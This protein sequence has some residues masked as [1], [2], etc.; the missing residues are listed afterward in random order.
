M[1]KSIRK[2]SIVLL[3]SLATLTPA[4]ATTKG[5]MLTVEIRSIAEKTKAAVADAE[6]SPTAENTNS[7][8]QQIYIWL[9]AYQ[10]SRA[11]EIQEIVPPPSYSVREMIDF[12]AHSV[13]MGNVEAASFLASYF[14]EQ[15]KSKHSSAA[16]DCWEA[17]EQAFSGD[18]H[19]NDNQVEHC[20][21]LSKH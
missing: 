3:M 4:S 19:P 7:A 1:F 17:V 15:P 5:Q 6:R 8:A 16:A 14:A 2:L 20:I 21:I 13:K 9:F 18:S 12:A 11:G 10:Y